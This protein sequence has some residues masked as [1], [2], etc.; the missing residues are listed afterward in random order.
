MSWMSLLIDKASVMP[1][2]HYPH[3]PGV[4]FLENNIIETPR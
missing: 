2:A 4:P 1:L 3:Y